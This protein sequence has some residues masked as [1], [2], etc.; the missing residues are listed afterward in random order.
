VYNHPSG[1]TEPSD[2]DIYLTEQLLQAGQVL[3][4][5]VVDHLILGDDH[6]SLRQTTGSGR[7]LLTDTF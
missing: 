5:P 1:N 4:V 7:P 2:S 3:N 6:C